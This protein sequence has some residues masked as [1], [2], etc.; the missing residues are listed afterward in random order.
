MSISEF[1]GQR[2]HPGRWQDDCRSPWQTRGGDT[3]RCIAANGRPL[4]NWFITSRVDFSIGHDSWRETYGGYFHYGFHQG[5][6]RRVD[7]YSDWADITPA[8]CRRSVRA[9]APNLAKALGNETVEVPA[10]ISFPF[11]RSIQGATVPIVI[12]TFILN[13]QAT[14]CQIRLTFS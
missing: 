5:V 8:E 10:A 1:S 7:F 12:M 14:G 3:A 4:Y 9:V 2:P 11:Q 13:N 6:L